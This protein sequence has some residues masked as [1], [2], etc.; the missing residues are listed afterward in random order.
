MS[1]ELVTFGNSRWL[2]VTGVVGG[3]VFGLGG[4]YLVLT[5]G[6][7]LDKW[8]MDAALFGSLVLGAGIAV[9]SA[10]FGIVIPNQVGGEAQWKKFAEFH[11][12]HHGGRQGRHRR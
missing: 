1:E 3:I 9:T 10:F 6:Q 12:S 2:S 4:A 8:V 5:L 11:E 7:G